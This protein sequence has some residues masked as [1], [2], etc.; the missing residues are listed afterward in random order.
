[1]SEPVVVWGASGHARVVA[2]LVRLDERFHLIG[3][4]DDIN[5]DR[6]GAKFCGVTILGGREQLES[7]REQ[8]VSRAFIAVGDCAARM[9]LAGVAQSSGFDI[10]TLI[11]PQAVVA[12]D[13]VLGTGTA[14]MAGAVVNPGAR[15]GA[16]VII[17]TCSCVEHG[18][19]VEDG[20]ALGPGVMLGGDVSVGSQTVVGIAAV[21][22]D[23]LRIGARSIIGAGAL[24][25]TDIPDEVV[26]FGLPARVI[27][28]I[29]G[30]GD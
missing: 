10:A 20:A 17:N 29:H 7:L 18:C 30:D 1:M 14:V 24:V 25:L 5:N 3:F 27:R 6:H 19:V 21:V 23:H 4:I 26:A 8:G 2:E 16:N 22:R 11:H 15:I 28:G 13:V 12:A 9:Q